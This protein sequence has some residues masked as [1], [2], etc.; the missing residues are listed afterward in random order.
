M[1]SSLINQLYDELSYDPINILRVRTLC[2]EN[3][4]LIALAGL[5]IKIWSLLLLGNIGY[6]ESNEQINLP[7][8]SCNEQHVL[9]ADVKRTRADVEEFRSTAWRNAVLTILQSFCL[10]HN[11]QY[12]QGM[13]EV[14]APFIFIRPP[15]TD[16]IGPSHLSYS[17]FEA[18][19][20][21]YLER[22]FCVDDSSFLFKTF[23]FF[24]LLLLYF[25]PQL[26]LHLQDQQFSPELY[27]PQWFLTLYSRSLPLSQVLRLWDMLISVDDPSFTFFIGL[28]L[29]RKKRD[30]LL[31]ADTDR[32]PE[33]IVKI[34]F[35]GEEEIDAIVIEAMKLYTNTPRSFLRNLRLCC[36]STTELTP[37]PLVGAAHKYS[38][39][40]IANEHD[41]AMS[42]QSVRSCFMLSSQDLVN[43]LSPIANSLHSI[44]GHH[45]ADII[46]DKPNSAIIDAAIVM[47]QYVLI[48]LRSYEESITSGGGIIPRAIQLEPQ[49]L[50]KPEAFNIWLQHFDGT[51]GCNICIID[52]PPPPQWTGMALWRRLLLGEG[53]GTAVLNEH[54][55]FDVYQSKLMALLGNRFENNNR[56]ND[57]SSLRDEQSKF[58][59]DESNVVTTDMSRP[60]FLLAAA[61]QRNAFSNISILEGGFPMLVEQLVLSRGSVEPVII[62]HE[63]EKWIQYL[64]STGRE[65]NTIHNNKLLQRKANNL[66]NMMQEESA[67]KEELPKRLSDLTNK[68]TLEL[69]LAVAQRLGHCNM[70][71][72]L[73]EKLAKEE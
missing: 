68:E 62:N 45:D 5:R 51:K 9:E 59:K 7:E 31:L 17:L 48:D 34:H 67:W 35:N 28:C 61:L 24:H 49:F 73:E 12:K 4:G 13:N 37:Q 69:A 70:I 18:F 1:A 54:D 33:I 8:K 55:L 58:A 38:I 53:D 71:T 52:I 27:S 25:D 6:V 26:A 22:Y 39:K 42:L 43:F 72:I 66:N 10:T 19:L 46:L 40:T 30:E 47:Q 14:L 21:R 44:S 11:I 16:N 57:S 64:K 15:T 50:N 65:Y 20:F 3:P 56:K 60:A 41:K 29:I 36:V 63:N 23:R 32:I 2:R